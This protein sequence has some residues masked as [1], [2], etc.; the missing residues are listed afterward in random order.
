MLEKAT[1]DK[2]IAFVRAKPRTMDEVAKHLEKNWRT[3]ERYVDSIATESGLIATRTFREGTRGALKVVYWNALDR[4]KGS[5]Y[6]ERLLQRIEL[7]RRKEDFSFFDIYQFVAPEHRFAFTERTEFP[8]RPELKYDDLLHAA[9]HQ[10]LFFSG[11]LSFTELGPHV[12]ETMEALAQKKVSMKLLTRIDV[13]S[14]KTVRTLL[15][16]NTRVGWDAIEIRH[17]EQPLR[18]TIFDDD[19]VTVKELLAPEHHRE[20]KKNLYVFYKIT[21]PDWIHW[22]QRVFWHLWGQSIDAPTRLSALK[23]LHLTE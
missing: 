11:N 20:L 7:S 17:C 2:I 16:L 10:V 5:A 13:I 12:L 8:T 9:E 19:A 21:D 22:L 18:L 23:T 1:T 14:E 15:E 3:A 4:A 6:Q